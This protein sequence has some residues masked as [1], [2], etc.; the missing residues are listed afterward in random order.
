MF[1]L[2]SCRLWAVCSLLALVAT[3][4]A[5]ATSPPA[6]GQEFTEAYLE[7]VK[8]SS[9]KYRGSG[10]WTARVE[11]A[12]KAREEFAA[13]PLD[14]R[15]TLLE[16]DGQG[17]RER[18]AVT[19]T[20]AVP[21]IP[22]LY[23]N[24]ATP[25]SPT[26]ARLDQILFT[27]PN[28]FGTVSDYYSEVSYGLLNLTGTV[29]NY[30]A[31]SQNDTFYEGSSTC[32][33]GSSPCYGLPP[34][35]RTGN[36]IR[37]TLNASDGGIDFSQFDNDGPDGMPNS[38]DDDG[39]VD[40]ISFLIPEVPITCG[41]GNPSI[42]PHRWNYRFWAV[43]G[44][45]PYTTNDP[46][47]G[48]GFI[49]IDD[50]NIQSS[51]NC[52]NG[53][54]D[55]GTFAHETGHIF[56]I[57]DLYDSDGNSSGVGEWSLMGSGNWN[58][59]ESPA[60][61]SA[62]EKATLGW[63]VPT[64][65]TAPVGSL[66]IPDVE[67][68]PVAYEVVVGNGEYFLIENRQPIGFDRFLHTCGLA[69]WHV[70]ESTIL[71]LTASNS[72]NT[73]QNCGIWVQ[74][75]NQH[76][77]LSLEQ[78]DA[79]CNLEAS[80]GFGNRGDAGDLYPGSSNNTAFT[81]TTNPNSASQVFGP[82]DVEVTNISACG[83]TMT[84]DINAFPIANTT[85]PVDV[86]FLIDN[87]GSYFDDWPN[88]KAQMPGIVAKL[89]ASFTNIR[90][91]L[92]LFRDYPFTPFGGT[93]DFA[94]R[95][96]LPLTANTANFLAAINAMQ[97]PGGGFDTPE[98]QY[99]ALFQTL[100]GAGRDL[101][102]DGVAGDDAGEIAP[103]NIG[104]VAGR[105]RVINLLTDAAFHDADS[106]NYP[107]GTTTTPIPTSEAIGR[108]GVISQINT[109]LGSGVGITLFTFVAN[110]PGVFVSVGQDGS[111]APLPNDPLRD[112]AEELAALTHGGIFFVG[113]DS[114]GLFEQITSAIS[115]LES[116]PLALPCQA[117]GLFGGF[118]NPPSS[119]VT[120]SGAGGGSS[121]YVVAGVP[122]QV[123]LAG[124]T[125]VAHDADAGVL[126]VATGDSDDSLYR[127]NLATGAVTL[128]G[129]LRFLDHNGVSQ[130]ITN[131]QA[132]DLAPA[133][134]AALGFEPGALYAVSIDGV[135]SCNPNCLFKVDP[136]TGV[137][138]QI[139]GLPLNQGR[140]ASFNPVTGQFWIFDAGGKNLY[141]VGATGTAVFEFQVPSSDRGRGTGI[142]TVFSLAHD[143]AGR[144]LAVDVA[145]GV[146]LEIDPATHQAYWL[147]GFGSVFDPATGSFDL[148]GLDL[149]VPADP[150][151]PPP[152]VTTPVVGL[153]LANP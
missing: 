16:R 83:A 100:T 35:G 64:L 57:P 24:S 85:A 84:A 134:S 104:W 20:V 7:F 87:S 73:R 137:G 77:G 5:L 78:A 130:S 33:G 118:H 6:P 143:C 110:N 96:E 125:T 61:M 74:T 129:P 80:G 18:M 103:S 21:V 121:A 63:L 40:L 12:R 128:V 17:L 140:G 98:S 76:Y 126:Y 15:R 124:V 115:V 75:A 25:G 113:R 81:A 79:N 3:S 92:A 82:T 133:V 72:V 44:G 45:V 51:R 42:W 14:E 2:R 91:G 55:I 62:W 59:Q 56:G 131:V 150:V 27:G 144:M 119:V 107:T 101:Y 146:L 8:Q 70:N 97:L 1:A 67:T 149:H 50:Y 36:L 43:S 88:I 47:A 93:G 99:E 38:G 86:V 136:A 141:T 60:H 68:N 19:G 122:V 152:V 135:G 10:G 132:M 142:D 145:Y 138:T 4:P 89:Q 102:S 37:D 114:S 109:L 39:I 120:V 52:A 148:Q 28:G 13:L 66:S 69:I 22:V 46:A 153:E 30:T 34:G 105:H 31:L 65:V 54:M 9:E 151:P 139:H 58:T 106:E 147:G 123:G 71:G 48:G 41:T 95:V 111:V 53:E 117:R 29:F 112:Q 49:R 11:L 23:A 116:Q 108:T 26:V 32:G 90:F 94:Y 127:V